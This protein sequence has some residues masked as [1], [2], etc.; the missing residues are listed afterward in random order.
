M[1]RLRFFILILLF[2]SLN[3]SF[4]QVTGFLED[5]N[6]NALTNW[7]MPH[8]DTFFLTEEDSVLKITYNR[9]SNTW[10][11]DNFNFIP[12][13]IDVTNNPYISV[14]VK[15]NI[16]TELTFKPIYENERNCN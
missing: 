12:P 10:E 1:I 13:L 9:T 8:Q 4:A 14:R 16:S 15:S 3:R 6:D 11:W 2:V 5:F 7:E